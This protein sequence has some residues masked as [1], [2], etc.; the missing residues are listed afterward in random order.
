MKTGVDSPELVDSVPDKDNLRYSRCLTLTTR[1]RAKQPIT[2][3]ESY[4]A[5]ILGDSGAAGR[6]DAIFSNGSLL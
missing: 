6:V 2:I 4:C 3:L 5:L 1:R